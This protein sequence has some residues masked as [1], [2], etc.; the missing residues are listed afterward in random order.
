M[1]RLVDFKPLNSSVAVKKYREVP[2]GGVTWPHKPAVGSSCHNEQINYTL[3]QTV[4]TMHN[5]L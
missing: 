5:K 2:F 3:S 1:P 4:T